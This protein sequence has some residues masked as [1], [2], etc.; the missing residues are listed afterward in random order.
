MQPTWVYKNTSEHAFAPRWTGVPGCMYVLCGACVCAHRAVLGGSAPVSVCLSP[1]SPAPPTESAG[2]PQAPCAWVLSPS[3]GPRPH[4]CRPSP[5][6]GGPRLRHPRFSDPYPLRL[7]PDSGLHPGENLD[8]LLHHLLLW[9]CTDPWPLR[10]RLCKLLIPTTSRKAAALAT[11]TRDT[12]QGA[13][14]QLGPPPLANW[15]LMERPVP[16][17]PGKYWGAGLRGAERRVHRTCEGCLGYRLSSRSGEWLM[18][19]QP[20]YLSLS[21]N[22]FFPFLALK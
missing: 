6:R 14:R 2:F 12:T 7:L 10:S 19:W 15:L 16:H 9:H 22:P 21:L 5:G 3:P 11:V 13:M 1:D 8:R 20:P 17:P 18:G 4:A